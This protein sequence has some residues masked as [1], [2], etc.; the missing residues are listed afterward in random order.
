VKILVKNPA[1]QNFQKYISLIPQKLVKMCSK[2]F[3]Y[4][5]MASGTEIFEHR[6]ISGST[7]NSEPQNVFLGW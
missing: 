1:T 6:G 5:K 3:F 2:V 7:E 4:P